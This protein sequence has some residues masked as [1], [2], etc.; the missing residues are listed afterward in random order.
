MKLNIVGLEGS[1]EV[2]VWPGYDRKDDSSCGNV[3]CNGRKD[4]IEMT[5]DD[6]ESNILTS[7]FKT[8]ILDNSMF[9]VYTIY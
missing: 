5:E 8:S 2:D 4:D 7:E 6:R 3:S 1:A 9:K